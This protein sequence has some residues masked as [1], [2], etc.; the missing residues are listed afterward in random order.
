MLPSSELAKQGDINEAKYA[1]T[2]I[3]LLLKM[4]KSKGGD[5]SRYRAKIAGG[6]QMF[7][8]QSNND[9]MRIGPRNVEACKAI[10][11][12]YK[13]PIIAED[14]GGNCGRTIEMDASTGIL[15]IR[16]VNQGVKEV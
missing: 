8:F 15:L 2:A 3:P 11:A 1:D 14:T 13:I 16:T 10:L 4:M 9:N 12:Q 6:A 5:V 7:V